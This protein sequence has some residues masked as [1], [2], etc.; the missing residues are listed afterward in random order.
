MNILFFRLFT[1]ISSIYCLAYV[2]ATPGD[3]LG[4]AGLGGILAGIY[5]VISK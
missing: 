2:A 4:L 5:I 1:F 3:Q